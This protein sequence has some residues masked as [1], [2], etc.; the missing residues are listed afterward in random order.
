MGWWGARWRSAVLENAMRETLLLQASEIA[1]G[2]DRDYISAL[3]FTEAGKA[4][5]VYKTIC[6][7]LGAYARV[8]RLNRAY[9]IARRN[10]EVVFGPV[11]SAAEGSDAE[12][13]MMS[14]TGLPQALDAVFESGAPSFFGPY[15]RRDERVFTAFAPVRDP[16]DSKVM[17][18]VGVDQPTEHFRAKAA[19]VQHIPAA[20]SVMLCVFILCLSAMIYWRNRLQKKDKKYLWHVETI[21]VGGVGVILCGGVFY[22]LLVLEQDKSADHFKRMFAAQCGVVWGRVNT[23]DCAINS[24]ERFFASSEQV[25]AGEFSRFARAQ[26]KESMLGV[27]EWLPAVRPEERAAYEGAVGRTIWERNDNGMKIPAGKREVYYPVHYVEP[28]SG[29]EMVLG[30]DPLSEPVRRA[31]LEEA[32]RLGFSAATTPIKLIQDTVGEPGIVVFNPMRPDGGSGD[33]P[34]RPAGFIVSALKFSHLLQDYSGTD[35]IQGRGSA[36]RLLDLSSPDGPVFVAGPPPQFGDGARQ[37]SHAVFGGQYERFQL[38]PLFAFG[39]AYALAG[40][41]PGRGQFPGISLAPWLIGVFGLLLT[42]MLTILAGRERSRHFH[43]EY[44][45]A[46]RTAE[47]GRSEELFREVFNA[48]PTGKMLLTP[49]GAIMRVNGAFCALTGYSEEELCRHSIHTIIQGGGIRD[50]VRFLMKV[51]ETGSGVHQMETRYVGRNGAE[52]WMQLHVSMVRH[53]LSLPFCY[54][55]QVQDVTARRRAEEER[56]LLLALTRAIVGV[57]D[58]DTVI[59]VVLR[60]ICESTKWDIGEV[61]FLSGDETRLEL[62]WQHSYR[63][64]RLREFHTESAGYAFTPGVGLPGRVWETR[65]PVWIPDINADETFL[66]RHMARKYGLKAAVGIPIMDNDRVIMVMAFF[67]SEVRSEERRMVDLVTAAAAQLGVAFQ[68]RRAEETLRRLNVELERRVAERTEEL[69]AAKEEAEVANKS[70]SVFLANM[71]HEIRTPMNAILGY[72]QLMR[73]LKTLSPE[74]A[75]YLETINKSGETLLAIINDILEMSKIESGR[76]TLHPVTFNLPA[77]LG[78]L[79]SLFRVRTMAKKLALDVCMAGTIPQ[80]VFADEGKVRQVLINMLGNAVKFTDKGGIEM[81][82]RAEGDDGDRFR[83][84]VEVEDTGC[85]IPKEEEDL[86]FQPFEQTRLA[87][88]REGTGLGMVISRKYARMMDGDL[89]LLRSQPGTGSVFCFEFTALRGE[90]AGSDDMEQQRILGLA[91]GQK[92]MH[93]LVVDDNEAN[94]GLFVRLL[95]QVGFKTR[96]AGNGMEALADFQRFRPDIILMDVLMPEMDGREAVRRIRQLPGGQEVPIIIISANSMEEDRHLAMESG[97]DSFLG[98]PFMESELL[99]EIR[100]LTGVQ[101][102]YDSPA[103]EAAADTPKPAVALCREEL[104][105]LSEEL[106]ESMLKAVATARMGAFLDMIERIREQNPRV[107]EQLRFIA[108]RFDYDTLM[109]LLGQD[110]G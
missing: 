92:E 63:H 54:V 21:M 14:G 13:G 6:G 74:Q 35:A 103:G 48:S 19:K 17:M 28:P 26:A 81:R 102:A 23:I 109:E 12:P 85:G 100:E 66:R 76:V 10:G 30:Y 7:Q 108:G 104:A 57:E 31:A 80:Y 60:M 39:K 59:A 8:A 40:D 55:V 72:A 110:G 83:I 75:E 99:R 67:L 47:L 98:K 101:Y 3:T 58:F 49:D 1:S 5:P 22:L 84:F 62:G 24:L 44:Q 38:C 11:G 43:L 25:E 73:R 61:W 106:R 16:M 56:G 94:R 95:G 107:A 87:A 29:N 20:L 88:H 36:L 105:F 4:H 97:A 51:A 33:V 96:E 93:V 64:E 89:R 37:V 46:R 86:V 32:A 69:M 9:I 91:P 34:E 78:H 45:V 50:L 68:R 27:L 52:A 77:L 79:D 70:K 18:V 82:V 90:Q 53:V 42:A 71:S 2:I 65:A 15:T 41:F